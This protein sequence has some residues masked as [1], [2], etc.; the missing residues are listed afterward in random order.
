MG[1]KD[2]VPLTTLAIPAFTDPIR[3]MLLHSVFRVMQ[4]SPS[5]STGDMG[6]MAYNT[7]ALVNLTATKAKGLDKRNTIM[8]FN[9]GYSHLELSVFDVAIT[10]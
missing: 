6:L 1:A 5:L 10:R 2:E 8:V 7:A 9:M 3:R 4:M